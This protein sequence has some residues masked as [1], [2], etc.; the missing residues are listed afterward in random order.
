MKKTV[1]TITLNP[2]LDKNSTID[3]LIPEKKLRCSMPK[4]DAGGGGINVSRALKRLG[5]SSS[6]IFT[7]GGSTGRKLENLLGLESL[8]L[9]PVRT[10]NETRENFI[11][12]DTLNSKQYRFGFPGELVTEEEQ[13]EILNNV[14]KLNPIPDFVVISGS[15]PV[16]IHPDFIRLLIDKC[17]LK[18]SKVIVDTSGDA[19]KAA[20]EEGVFLVKPNQREL[21]ELAGRNELETIDMDK[22]ANSIISQGKASI[23]VV[24]LGAKG[25]ILYSENQKIQMVPP[26]VKIRSTVGAGDSM[27]AGMVWALTSQNGLEDV[28]RKGIACGTA[29]TLAEGTGLFKIK[30]VERIYD[31]IKINN[32]IS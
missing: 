8:N 27:V 14:E 16:G 5:V 31:Q 32:Q 20:V 29:T 3:N 23:L 4:F 26:L 7:S 17:K 9:F 25:A 24:S 30:D 13:N 18:G 11:V 12:T 15:L 1:L 28:L 6:V 21:S 22:Q 10:I 19:L 2:A